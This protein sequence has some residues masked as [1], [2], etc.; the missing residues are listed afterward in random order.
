[1]ENPLW[2]PFNVIYSF[3][4]STRGSGEDGKVRVLLMSSQ[5]LAGTRI[6]HTAAQTPT[7]SQKTCTHSGPS[8][9]LLI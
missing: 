7:H 3:F 6:T 1:M 9:F 5:G 4:G 2:T 8:S